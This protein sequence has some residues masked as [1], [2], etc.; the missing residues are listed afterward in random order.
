M[1]KLL[2]NSVYSALIESMKEY[3]HYVEE[4]LIFHESRKYS[5][6]CVTCTAFPRFNVDRLVGEML[7]IGR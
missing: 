5:L 6:L 4:I 3:T 7:S 2:E 1:E